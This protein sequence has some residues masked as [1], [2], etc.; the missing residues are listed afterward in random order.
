MILV[1]GNFYKISSL[2]ITGERRGFIAGFPP[3]RVSEVIQNVKKADDNR[4][5]SKANRVEG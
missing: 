2:A 4:G 3:L 1:G 5:S